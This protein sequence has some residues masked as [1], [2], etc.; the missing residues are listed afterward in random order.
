MVRLRIVLLSLCFLLSL[1][2]LL[3]EIDG[4]W[5]N[6]LLDIVFPAFWYLT[7]RGI[8]RGENAPPIL[9]R[10]SPT[11]IFGSLIG[12]TFAMEFGQYFGYYWGTY[13]PKD[14][15][16]YLILL[17]PCYLSDIWARRNREARNA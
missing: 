9:R 8:S 4:F 3:V 10:L 13:D 15:L 1:G 7:I 14:F 6:Y 16:A 11:A 17:G 2:A 5:N 12:I